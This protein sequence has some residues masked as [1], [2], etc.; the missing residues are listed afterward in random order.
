MTASESA[1][2]R[3]WCE[4]S[5]EYPW[6]ARCMQFLGLMLVQSELS[7]QVNPTYLIIGRQAVGCTALEDHS[8]VHDVGPISNAQRFTHIVVGDEH[9][10]AAVLEMKNDLLDV[11]DRYRVDA[12]KRL[13]EQDEFRG[14]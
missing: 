7:P 9:T 1:S 13:V 10:D 2:G 5:A 11:T 8:P 3:D 4:V 12:G 6:A 14:N